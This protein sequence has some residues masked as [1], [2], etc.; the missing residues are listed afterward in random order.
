MYK[1]ISLHILSFILGLKW[2]FP[3][4]GAGMNDS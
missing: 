2:N 1:N 3:A 4:D